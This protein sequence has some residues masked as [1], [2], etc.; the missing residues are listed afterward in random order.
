MVLSF[1]VAPLM[2]NPKRS[3]GSARAHTAGRLADF[4]NR[5]WPNCA[6]PHLLIDR[7][8]VPRLVPIRHDFPWTHTTLR[9]R[10]LPPS[11]PR[12]PRIVDS[13]PSRFC[14]KMR[15]MKICLNAVEGM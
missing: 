7:R 13:V 12:L 5:T 10:S 1:R 2:L 11:A 6:N 14:P 9:P 4:R 15:T 3:H 8:T